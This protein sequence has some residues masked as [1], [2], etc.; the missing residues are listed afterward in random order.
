MAIRF[1]CNCHR[2][3]QAKNIQAGKQVRCPSCKKIMRVPYG[4]DP[5]AME[6]SKAHLDRDAQ[7][8]GAQAGG[9]PA[10]APPPGAA[11]PPKEPS[12]DDA[13]GARFAELVEDKPPAGGRPAAPPVPGGQRPLMD[14]IVV[15][16]IDDPLDESP[17][18]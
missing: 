3:L 12:L 6:K 14:P 1:F 11:P 4:S 17:K 13:I 15:D 18:P 2:K 10:A 16:P 5:R 8:G 7:Q 9:P